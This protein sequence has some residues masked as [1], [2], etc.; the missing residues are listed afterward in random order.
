MHPR[1]RTST[2]GVATPRNGASDVG[3]PD[4]QRDI[5]RVTAQQLATLGVEAHDDCP[6]PVQFL[7]SDGAL[8]SGP[9]T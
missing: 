1:L 7:M 8:F 9:L 4:H 5:V 2:R 6:T 3:T